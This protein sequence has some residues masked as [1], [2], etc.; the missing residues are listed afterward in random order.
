MKPAAKKMTILI[1]IAI[2][3]LG[4]AGIA[5]YF[6][7]FHRANPPLPTNTVTVNDATFNVEIASTSVEQARGLSYRASLG[8]NDGMLFIFGSS[9]IQHFWMKDMN[10]PLDMIWVSGNTVV[11][12]V[13]NAEPK[14]GASLLS[15]PIYTS[16]DKTDK[17]LEVNAGVVARYNI[18]VGDTI[19][20]SGDY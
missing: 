9:S 19:A 16:P 10:F 12:F 8:T 1:S 3:L 7:I 4:I 17:V 13:Q 2:I 11:G 14:P 6:L 18:K 5:A 15:L 20:I